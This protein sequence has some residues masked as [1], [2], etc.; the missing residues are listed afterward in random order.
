MPSAVQHGDSISASVNQGELWRRWR[1]AGISIHFRRDVL[2]SDPLQL[3]QVVESHGVSAKLG[4]DT[5]MVTI[6]NDDDPGVLTFAQDEL[7]VKE[8]CGYVDVR[9]QRARAELA[10][11]SP[12]NRSISTGLL[13]STLTPIRPSPT[14]CHVTLWRGVGSSLLPPSPSELLTHATF[15]RLNQGTRPC[16]GAN[17][18]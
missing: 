8:T 12:A 4:N 6:V 3:R 10:G 7:V 15:Q 11:I 18:E 1:S 2:L 9:G 13:R 14:P 17:T 5:T 16:T